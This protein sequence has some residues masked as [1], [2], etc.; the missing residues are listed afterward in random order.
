MV[1]LNGKLSTVTGA[2]GGDTVNGVAPA[3]IRKPLVT[4]QPSE[5]QRRRLLAQIPAGRF[6]EA[7]EVAHLVRFLVAPLSGFITG[8]IVDINGGL[9]LD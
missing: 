5:D 4:E 9:R 1:S 6:C 3:Y 2:A 8:E 7:A